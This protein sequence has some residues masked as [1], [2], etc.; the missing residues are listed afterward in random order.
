[1]FTLVPSTE[2]KYFGNWSGEF[3]VQFDKYKKLV[4][5]DESKAIETIINKLELSKSAYRSFTIAGRE[6]AITAFGTTI[7]NKAVDIIQGKKVF[8][9]FEPALLVAL[10]Y[11]LD[12]VIDK[13]L[14]TARV[15]E[16]QEEI[17]K[18]SELLEKI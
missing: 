7:I 10:L 15:E 5:E 11:L 4:L 14:L 17:A 18:L 2:L 6:R 9:T 1:M 3:H 8:D 12:L 13:K 16:L